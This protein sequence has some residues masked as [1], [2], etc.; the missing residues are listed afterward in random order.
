MPQHGPKGDIHKRKRRKVVRKK[1]RV[2]K[3]K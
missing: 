2:A 1:R 3:K